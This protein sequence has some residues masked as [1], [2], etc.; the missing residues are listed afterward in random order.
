MPASSLPHLETFA[1]AAAASSFTAAARAL[2][3]TQAAVS[4]RIQAL[5]HELGTALFHRHG[6][7][8]L[9]TEA[10]Q[11]LYPLA[12]RIM[13]LHEEARAV[14]GSRPI[15]ITGELSLAASSVPGEHLLPAALAGFAKKFPHIH[16]RAIITDSQ[17]VLRRV[18]QG[19][20]H[21]G[22]VG[23]KIDHPHLAFRSFARDRMVVLVPTNHR[24]SG[25]RRITLDQL[26]GE[27]L[28]LREVG[29]GSRWRLEQALAEAGK[30]LADFRVA[31][32][33]GSNEAI[34]EA[35]LQGMGAAILSEEAAGKELKTKELR[36]LQVAGLSMNRDLCI[37]WD[38]RRVLPIP[39]QHFLQFLEAVPRR[40]GKP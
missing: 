10:G 13:Q 6:G 38:R 3:L 29:S 30:T 23:M 15:R 25:R 17:G 33:L 9:L 26:A 37:V 11:R 16:V 20:A 34:K 31:L 8:V 22:L 19:Q 27:P 40:K 36:A 24:W 1:A 35:V 4:Q 7:R 5:E 2:K 12:Q 21:V 32:E 14:A 39:A 18:E 28:V